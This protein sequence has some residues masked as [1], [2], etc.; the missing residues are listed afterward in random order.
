MAI[1]LILSR[2]SHFVQD[3]FTITPRRIF[4]N[5]VQFLTWKNPCKKK[6]HFCIK[7]FRVH[8]FVIF[9]DGKNSLRGAITTV[10]LINPPLFFISH[11]PFG[12]RAVNHL[13]KFFQ[14]SQLW[15]TW[16]FHFFFSINL[17][18]A[19]KKIQMNSV[20][21]MILQISLIATLTL[22][23]KL[24]TL[25][26]IYF[27]IFFKNGVCPRWGGI[28]SNRYLHKIWLRRPWV[29]K[30]WHFRSIK[31]KKKTDR[32]NFQWK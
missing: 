16:T 23:H 1:G 5:P 17:I 14:Q 24:D 32:I 21:K 9:L 27:P 4:F 19:I 30:Q 12:P 25:K 29:V 11:V 2:F 13:W 3:F 8:N 28:A 18:K 20:S 6:V 31:F 26:M 15:E 7:T 22:N 10:S